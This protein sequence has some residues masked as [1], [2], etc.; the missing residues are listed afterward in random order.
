MNLA[1]FEERYQTTTHCFLANM[2]AE[3]LEDGDLEYIEW[4]GE[5]SLLKGLEEE[6]RYPSHTRSEP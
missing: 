5:A 1:R 2:T 4:A 3:D 6:L